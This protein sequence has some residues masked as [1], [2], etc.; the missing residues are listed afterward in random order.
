MMWLVI[1]AL[2]LAAAIQG[3]G[4]YQ[5]AAYVYQAKSDLTGGHQWAAARVSLESKIPSVDDLHDALTIGDYNISNDEDLGIISS[6]GH[7][8][9]M[10]VKAANVNSN[11]V[12]WSSSDDPTNIQRGTEMPA[13]CGYAGEAGGPNASP[14]DTDGDGTPNLEDNDIDNDGTPN[15]SDPDI[16]GDG[17]P[18]EDDSDIDGDRIPNG[19]DETPNGF[20]FEVDTDGDGIPNHTDDDLDGDGK[21]NLTD[22]DID[23]DGSLNPGDLTAWGDASISGPSMDQLITPAPGGT[24]VDPRVEMTGVTVSA[25]HTIAAKLHLDLTGLP[26]NTGPYYGVSYRLTCEL[27]DGSQFFKHSW[28][29]TQYKGDSNPDPVHNFSCPLDIA[30]TSVVGWVVGPAGGHPALTSY[31]GVPGPKNY[32][33]G[34]QFV[35]LT[36]HDESTAA[37][38]GSR[39]ARVTLRKIKTN[40]SSIDIGLALDLGGVSNNTGPYYGYTYRLNCQLADGSQYYKYGSLYTQY[41]GSTYPAPTYNAACSG[42]DHL[43]GYA[44]GPDGSD[45]SVFFGYSGQPGP[46]NIMRGGSQT[47]DGN[48][49]TIA[50]K[51]GAPLDPR[52]TVRK[53]TY[54]GANAS[55]GININTG[56][57]SNLTGPYWG[58]SYRLTCEASNGAISYKAGS[59]YTSYTGKTYPAPA[60][61]ASCPAGTTVVGHVVGADRSHDALTSDSGMPGPKD[62]GVGGRQS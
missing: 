57:V 25:P 23:G 22:D 32:L 46:T 49:P 36:G 38:T 28:L 52:V 7:T 9:C 4:Y 33:T 48:D 47:Q 5:Q 54:S 50:P 59:L 10:G 14:A 21:P 17:K 58:Y 51:A 30:G 2:M 26:N 15:I 31:P 18:N 24:S 11:N 29:W 37:E 55:I 53:V 39:D 1:A 61:T 16:D 56:G 42:T 20:N 45:P 43:I 41:T 44:V 35:H 40:T 27:P 19:K 8:Y 12:F 34:G 60:Y 13:S 62:V 3:I 6:L